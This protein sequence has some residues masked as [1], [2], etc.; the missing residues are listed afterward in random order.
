MK[1]ADPR[2]VRRLHQVLAGQHRS[3]GASIPQACESWAEVKGAY[4]LIKSEVFSDQ[5]ILASHREATLRRIRR[6]GLK[7]VL[8]VQD[9]TSLNY[10]GR[11]NTRGL[12]PIGNN[13]DKTMGLF[14]HEQLCL[15]AENG[16]ALGLLG[17]KLWAREAQRFKR[18]PAGARNRQ[19]IEAKE[20]CRWLEGYQNVQRL[21]QELGPEVGVTS[22][23]DREG[24]IYEVFA[25]WRHF[26]T[27]GGP[28][29]Q[30]LVRAQHNRAVSEGKQ[31][32]HE[33][34]SAG[35]IQAT[36]TVDVSAHPGRKARQAKLEV[37]FATVELL[38]PVNL[39]KYQKIHTPLTL[40][41]IIARE[42]EPPPGQE[43]L[44]WSLWCSQSV[45]TAADALHQLAHYRRRWQ[46][47]VLHRILKSGCK[48]EQRQLETSERLK[49]LIAVDLM[50]A[51]Y[52]L[53]LT[54]AARI[55]PDAP[56]T[57]WL[58]C[59]EQHA[60]CAFVNKTRDT[61]LVPL[62]LHTAIRWLGQLGGHLG[63]K[64][65]GPPGPQSLWRGLLRLQDITT[66]WSL[67]SSLPPSSTCG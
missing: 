31:R 62:A 21:A 32:S 54:H 42:P 18:G 58:S 51:V 14:S 23:A 65:D 28:V 47:E 61:V 5:A 55:N 44:E 20:S 1:P 52:L 46:I 57:D 9:T 37:R 59:D 66:A 10:S 50:I 3:P 39:Q 60:L 34:V 17:A 56:A 26:A 25:Q 13:A 38:P 2:C 22:V 63:R 41:L 43:A 30:L 7:E 8:V 16:A 40:S 36:V 64:S 12:G 35:A 53:G 29:A 15:D 6:T 67:F 48:V 4:R 33:Q 11:D 27:Q 45:E 49:L 24:D 19:P